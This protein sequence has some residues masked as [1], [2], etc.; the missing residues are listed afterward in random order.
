MVETCPGDRDKPPPQNRFRP[1]RARMRAFRN[2]A[3]MLPRRPCVRLVFGVGGAQERFKVDEREH[4][5]HL[6]AMRPVSSNSMAHSRSY[7]FLACALRSAQRCRTGPVA[8][9]PSLICTG[10]G[11][12]NRRTPCRRI[13]CTTPTNPNHS[14]LPRCHPTSKAC[15][16]LAEDAPTVIQ[17]Q[18]H[19]ISVHA[20]P[21][22]SCRRRVGNT[23]T[24]R[25]RLLSTFSFHSPPHR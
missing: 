6:R 14:Q 10:R 11:H 9:M 1:D 21:M 16:E 22:M 17:K 7:R 23:E 3:Y 8:S 13:A 25:R 18:L 20:K 19:L 5:P 24:S 4:A 2:S 15:C 12:P